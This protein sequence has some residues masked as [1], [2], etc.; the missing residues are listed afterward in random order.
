MSGIL[1]PYQTGEIKKGDIWIKSDEDTLNKFFTENRNEKLF[2][3]EDPIIF[4]RLAKQ[5]K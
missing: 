1:R 5:R 2:A 3:Y 4:I